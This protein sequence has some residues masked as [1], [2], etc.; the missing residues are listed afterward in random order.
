M[1]SSPE[2]AN[3]NEFYKVLNDTVTNQLRLQVIVAKLVEDDSSD[4]PNDATSCHRRARDAR[5][6]T[7]AH[8]NAFRK[9]A[10]PKALSS[11]AHQQ[12]G[13]HQGNLAG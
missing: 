7:D 5:R 11:P 6:N 2:A 1:S 13:F 9:V 8:D 10:T 12:A 4:F 3:E